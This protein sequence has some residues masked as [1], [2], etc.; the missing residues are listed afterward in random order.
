M[1]NGE[2]VRRMREKRLNEESHAEHSMASEQD[3]LTVEERE[4]KRDAMSRA[5]PEARDQDTNTAPD[6]DWEEGARL[7]SDK[8]G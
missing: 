3:Q 8:R 2:D 6:P 4:R 7:P 1:G 5:K